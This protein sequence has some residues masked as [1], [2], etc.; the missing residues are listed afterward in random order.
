MKMEI[1]IFILPLVLLGIVFQFMPLMTR[2][3]IFF[4]ATVASDFPRSGEGRRRLRSF[5]W[6][7]AIWSAIAIALT[8]LL[9]PQ[10]PHYAGLMPVL[11]LITAVGVSYARKFHEVHDRYGTR[12]PELRQAELTADGNEVQGV[13]FWI[14]LP[15]F[16]AIAALALYLHLHWNQL[17]DPYPVHFGVH[18]E[19][20]RWAHRDWTSVYLPLLVVTMTNLLFVGLSWLFARQ[21][22]KT[23]MRQISIRYLQVMAYPV[24]LTFVL[25]GLLPV[26]PQSPIW[27]GLIMTFASIGVLIYWSYRRLNS[28]VAAD[29]S[30]EPSSDNYWKAGMFY[31]NPDDPSIFVAKRVG[32]GYTLNFA[33]KMCWLVLAGVLLLTLF[34]ALLA[35]LKGK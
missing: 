26:W 27:L 16:V 12:K 32:I 24:T 5:R 8:V 34:P 18:N 28:P 22:R 9:T 29:E 21:S 3:G 6:Q 19:P 2:P 20:N 17:P 23:V 33:N 13:G 25:V 7:A 15:P 10:Y 35:V 14:W 31:Y 4:G 11:L 30:P 1:T